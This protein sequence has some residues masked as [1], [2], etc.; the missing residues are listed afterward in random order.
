MKIGIDAR[1]WNESGVGRYIRNLV[2]YLQ[3]SD[4]KNEYVLFVRASDFENEKWQMA[5]D[6]WKII[7]TDIR[8]HTL[9]EQLKFSN[10]LEKENL[11]LVHFPYF[12]IPL[13]YNKPFVVTIHDLILHHFPTGKATTLP[14][15]LY[16]LKLLS[17]KHIIAQAAKRAQKIITVS[18]STKTEIVDHLKVSPD[19]IF[20]TYEGIDQKISN[21]PAK[22]DRASLDK[23]PISNKTIKDIIDK[24]YFLYVG[25]A[26][27]H[28]NLERLIEA[29]HQCLKKDSHLK[30][31]LV[32]K[33][34]Y[35]Y[36]RL[37]KSVSLLNLEDSVLFYNNVTDSDLSNLYKNALALVMPSLMEGF[38]LPV[39]EAL[40]QKC[41]VVC[42]D[43]P[44]FKEI[45]GNA[46]IYFD[47]L[48]IESISDK[49]MSVVNNKNDY[50]NNITTGLEKIKTY[51]WKNTAIQ[52]LKIY[53]SSTRIRQS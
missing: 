11:D 49:M 6:R 15:P 19:K 34:D 51:T 43:I 8:W 9:G 25:N 18:K 23:F 44:V 41:L 33:E 32:G 37:K 52:T 3:T 30:L 17:Y 38:G 12:S 35:F 29:F 47:P 13:N 16:Y 24:K 31:I 1:L 28:K 27:P 22:R 4:K 46:G 10:I 42:S 40:S 21:F 45:I 7:Q 39:I 2:Q 53:E 20:V 5:N 48:D 50:K 36:K 26:Y 14:F